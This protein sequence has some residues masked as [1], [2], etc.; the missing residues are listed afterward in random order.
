MLPQQHWVLQNK[1]LVPSVPNCCFLVASCGIISAHVSAPLAP[2]SSWGCWWNRLYGAPQEVLEMK[3]QS[4]VGFFVNR[5]PSWVL[6]PR[7]PPSVPSLGCMHFPRWHSAAPKSHSCLASVYWRL[8]L[9]HA[10]V[11]CHT[12]ISGGIQDLI[13]S[14]FVCLQVRAW[15]VSLPACPNIDST[16]PT[17]RRFSCMLASAT[18]TQSL[19][20]VSGSFPGLSRLWLQQKILCASVLLSCQCSTSFSL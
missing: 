11:I 6:P 12:L 10:L 3:P 14:P 9:C 4:L 7:W 18:A 8:S 13:P 19:S 20:P 5:V 17:V 1:V 15:S 2:A 16:S